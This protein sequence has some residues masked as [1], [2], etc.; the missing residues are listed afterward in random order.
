MT[1]VDTVTGE[2]VEALDRDDAERLSIRIGARLDTIADNYVAVLPMIR[3]AIERQ[4][5]AAL[6]YRSPGEYVADR[7][8][9][10]LSKLGVDVRRAVVHEL[11]AAGLSTRA[12]APVVGVSQ[13]QV[14]RDSQVTRDVSPEPEC[15]RPAP[16]TGIDGKTYQRLDHRA[17]ADE[18]VAEFPELAYFRDRG[19]AGD[20]E[21][22]WRLADSLREF[23]Q[24]GEYD[25]R[26][27][28][29]RRSIEVDRSK[30]DGTY[31]PPESPAPTICA[32]CGQQ[33][34]N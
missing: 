10:S 14:V 8:G 7:F 30:R 2:I 6:G 9:E 5:H 21:H 33:V 28:I 31:V 15:S 26:I 22:T 32:A 24:R 3:E 13:Q 4:A 19:E 11:T 12:I 25:E 16:V 18:A 17:R 34:R 27:A 20:L 29:L 23:R 1:S